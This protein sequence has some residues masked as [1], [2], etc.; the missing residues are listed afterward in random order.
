MNG[1]RRS[2]INVVA[3]GVVVMTLVLLGLFWARCACS[4]LRHSL[5][6][7]VTGVIEIRPARLF[8]WEQPDDPNLTT[9]S[10]VRAQMSPMNPLLAGLGV[11]H[12]VQRRLPGGP[13]SNVYRWGAEPSDPWVYYDASLGQM[14]YKGTDRIR[15]NDGTGTFRYF[16]YYAGP[17]GVSEAPDEKL[18]RFI[19]PVVDP[20]S[21]R[22][23]VIYDSGLRG[24]FA[25]HWQE[26]TITKGPELAAGDMH[27]PVQVGLLSK[28]LMSLRVDFL[29]AS[30]KSRPASASS[31][32]VPGEAESQRLTPV[33]VGDICSFVKRVLVLDASG[34]IDL[35][36]VDT[37][38][39]V[40]EAGRLP[41][42][43]TLFRS[44]TAVTPDDVAAYCVEPI[45]VSHHGASNSWTYAGCAA[46]ALS[47]DATAMRLELFDPNGRLVTSKDTKLLRYTGTGNG[48]SP[49]RDTISSVRAAYF[50]VPGAPTL[51]A[52]KF[53]LENL[54]PPVFL[55]SSYLA[56]PS[57]EATSAYRSLVLLPESFVAMQAGDIR[58]GP[59]H[60]FYIAGLLM[61][62]AIGLVVL[63]ASLVARD[64]MKVGLSKDARAI[65][66]IGT[67]VFGLP[68]YIT[69]RLTRP[70]IRLVTCPNCGQARRPDMERC[71]RCGSLWI[72]PELTPPAWRVVEL[73]ER[74]GNESS[75]PAQET[76]S[77]A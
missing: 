55:L 64:G 60:R 10:G 71:H 43:A 34:R 24:F 49:P 19:A 36:D 30:F 47:R 48:Q 5:L 7:G 72:V 51:T 17:E 9:A 41:I 74:A 29:P 76:I 52:V 3:T 63:L 54:H 39:F 44:S 37:L 2:L 20:F 25:I 15:K 65:W 4:D 68:A 77:E 12:Y 40:G 6:S 13:Y 70:S 67:V 46:G 33:A 16:T 8:P 58:A 11:V 45:V 1:Q 66:I 73:P 50:G 14:V 28:N 21:L 56:A 26:R 62:P 75:A 38:E 57:F 32:A 69:Y 53:A 23:W 61:L 27:R 42:P 35:L 31:D 22:P 59:I 18:G